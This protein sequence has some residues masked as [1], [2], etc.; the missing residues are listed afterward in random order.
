MIITIINLRCPTRPL[1]LSFFSEK[2][3]SRSIS[4]FGSLSCKCLFLSC[5]KGVAI[6]S[7]LWLPPSVSFSP[8]H[9]LTHLN[10]FGLASQP[11]LHSIF[12]SFHP[13]DHKTT[14]LLL[15]L[16]SHNFFFFPFLS[17]GSSRRFPSHHPCRVHMLSF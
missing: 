4:E 1:G 10:Y 3:K 11:T 12:L 13:P 9:H 8:P 2:W 5:P 15:F 16:T 7:R 17:L 6:K 14:F